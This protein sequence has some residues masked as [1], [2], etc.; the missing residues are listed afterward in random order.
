M[1]GAMAA[2]LLDLTLRPHRS[3]SARGFAMLMGLLCAI[4]FVAGAAF[5]AVGA[6]PVVG[7]LGVDVLLV[8]IALR[9]S[10]AR[11]RARE[12]LTLHEDRFEIERIDRQ[13]RRE[14]RSL[15]PYW[16]KVE[17]ADQ[18]AG[19]PL[20]RL[21]SHGKS[22]TVGTFLGAGERVELARAIEDALARWRQSPSTSRIE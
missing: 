4:S 19:A 2:P 3:L 5:V 14:R 22:T 7:F 10:F 6:W 12:R 15:E 13:G 17:L 18:G 8:W 9:V 1:L 20:V 16:L 21:R 11:G